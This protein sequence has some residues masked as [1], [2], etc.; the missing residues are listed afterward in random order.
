MYY[1]IDGQHKYSAAQK[2]KAAAEEA[3]KEAPA[4]TNSF[5][6][7]I[8]KPDAT[9]DV[10]QKVAGW[11]Q[12]KAQNVKRQA[13]SQSMNMFLSLYKKCL[14]EAKAVDKPAKPNVSEMLKE[15][16]VKSGRGTVKDGDV[17]CCRD[18]E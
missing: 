8:V 11:M 5:R 18:F 4:W 16:Y 10:R 3:R 6:C 12:A 9:L 17:V 13:I 2:V 15:V 1:I 14:A 7:S